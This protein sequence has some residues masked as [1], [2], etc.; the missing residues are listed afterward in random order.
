M[1]GQ[2]IERVLMAVLTAPLA[3]EEYS[4]WATIVAGDD[5]RSVEIR[6]VVIKRIILC[7]LE[8]CPSKVRVLTCE[9]DVQRWF[10]QHMQQYRELIKNDSL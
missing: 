10:D 3:D 6:A 5:S 4:Q 9:E 2:K 7:A 1:E 8:K